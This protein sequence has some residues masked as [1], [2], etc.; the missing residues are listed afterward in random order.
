MK[1]LY[2]I[3]FFA[4]VFLGLEYSFSRFFLHDEGGKV[5]ANY[6]SQV[7]GKMLSSVEFNELMEMADREIERQLENY[8][9]SVKVYFFKWAIFG[10]TVSFFTLYI[11]FNILSKF[12]FYVSYFFSP[13]IASFIVFP[14]FMTI[15]LMVFLWVFFLVFKRRFNLNRLIA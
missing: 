1:T 4:L 12:D 7:E 3:V 9:Q 2:L 8:D 14:I 5:Y 6:Y 11:L 10:L 13:V 15:A